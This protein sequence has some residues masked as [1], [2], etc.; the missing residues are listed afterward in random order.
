[1]RAGAVTE[2]AASNT[3]TGQLTV[4]AVDSPATFQAVAIATASASGYGSFTVTAAGV[5]SYALNNANT[6]VNALNTGQ[7]LADSFVVTAADGTTQTIAMTINGNTD[8]I[9]NVIVGAPNQAVVTGTAGADHIIVGAGNLVVNARG[10]GDLITILPSSGP[11]LIRGGSG[12]DTLDYSLFTSDATIDL[13]NGFA[14]GN[15]FF[16]SIGNAVGGSGND[17]LIGN[18]GA[19]KLGGGLGNDS[20]TGGLGAD[21][22]TGGSGSDTFIFNDNHSGVDQGNRDTITDFVQGVDK[23]DIRLFDANVNQRGDQ[24]F[25]SAISL[26]NGT[27]NEFATNSQAT[28]K[29]HY[30]TIAGEQFTVID[31]NNDSDS[32]A[33]AQIA[34]K[35]FYLFNNTSDFLL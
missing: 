6:T 17:A 4:T 27:G 9:Y 32:L 18:A 1:V 29:Y 34:L 21:I 2:D 31:L 3:V 13:S 24:A 35:G 30:E 19:N 23:L 7:V 16:T 10:G 14:T 26:W 11:H 28:L 5:W 8:S 33:D 25:G 12:D 22:L 20:I 15:T